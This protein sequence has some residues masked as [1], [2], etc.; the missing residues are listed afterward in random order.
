MA[1]SEPKPSSLCAVCH[2]PISVTDADLVCIHGPLRRRCPGSRQQPWSGPD[3]ALSSRS[4]WPCGTE[5]INTGS[6][7]TSPLP[8]SQSLSECNPTNHSLKILKRIP[9]ASRE[10]AARKLALIVEVVL[11]ANDLAAWNCLFSFC[12]LCL[13]A[14]RRGGHRWNLASEV[15]RQIRE[16]VDPPSSTTSL[17]LRQWP[18]SLELEPLKS[19]AAR[20]VA[21]L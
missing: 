14:P 7:V 10:P 5:E 17:C 3:N 15:N 21:K 11:V 6:A 13:C 16:E 18:R 9:W 8:L 12:S 2:H 4:R 1:E 19:L 20:V